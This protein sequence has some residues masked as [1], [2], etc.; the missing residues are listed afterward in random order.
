MGIVRGVRADGT[1]FEQRTNKKTWKVRLAHEKLVQVDLTALGDTPALTEMSLSYE[2]ALET[3]DLAPLAGHP[4][5]SSL[6]FTVKKRV[7]LAPLARTPLASLA[8]DC[9][10]AVDLSVLRGHP[11]LATLAV[12]IIGDGVTSLDLGVVRDLPKLRSLSVSGGDWREL[13]LA[14]LRGLSLE[15]LSLYKQY[16]EKVDL[17]IVAQPA[18]ESL[19]LQE[20]EL[21]EGYLDL[22]ELAASPKLRFLSLLGAE[23]GTLDVS[24]L[25]RLPALD[26]FDL[27]NYKEMTRMPGPIASPA[28]ARLEK[29]GLVAVVD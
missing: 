24:T 10:E 19:M 8:F 27:P 3:I 14:P 4:A 20:L 21:R 17:G 22:H 5:L 29:Q 13:D 16:I 11:T 18:L 28:I 9:A 2:T 6:S 23:V 25:A 1:P 15:S 12:G 7:D 26:R